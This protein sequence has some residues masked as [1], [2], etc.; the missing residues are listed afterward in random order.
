M[1]QNI[2]F[3]Y[4][5][6]LSYTNFIWP[7]VGAALLYFSFTN[8]GGLAYRG[9]LVLPY[10]ASSYFYGLAGILMLLPLFWLF[11]KMQKTH[12]ILLKNNELE[13]TKGTLKTKKV[14]V[15]FSK[16]EKIN[17]ENDEDYGQL[18]MIDS[19]KFFDHQFYE[20][21]FKSS[22]DFSKFYNEIILRNRAIIEQ[23][24]RCFMLGGIY[25]I[26][27]YGGIDSVVKIIKQSTRKI[28]DHDAFLNAYK[29]ILV[30]PFEK[31]QEKGMKEF[32]ETRWD[33]FNRENLIETIQRFKTREGKH[34]AWDYVRIAQI[35]A[36]GYAC[37]YLN[38]KEVKDHLLELLPIVQERYDDW[39]SYYNDFLQGRAT[40]SP[41]DEEMP[42]YKE[43]V[44]NLTTFERSIYGMLPLK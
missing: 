34:K 3:Q 26:Y 36:M 18:V 6:K 27:G 11:L 35:A 5:A 25:F 30:F 21:R 14:T 39:S 19:G 31:D 20:S 2:K 22:S 9:K 43:I 29:E 44:S 15:A 7:C 42:I 8:T 12:Y 28:A 13:Y 41:N 17:L 23:E 4:K 37:S 1:E 10:P 24:L 33:I 32:F 16:M 40:W 38:E